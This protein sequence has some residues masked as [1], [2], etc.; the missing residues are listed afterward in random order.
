MTVSLILPSKSEPHANEKEKET[1]G[2][3]R[4]QRFS[5][6]SIRA[7]GWEARPLRVQGQGDEGRNRFGE[8]YSC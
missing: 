7:E 1:S 6:S 3:R 8:L 4:S 2:R 5:P